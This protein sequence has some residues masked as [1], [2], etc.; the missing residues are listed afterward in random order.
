M[1]KAL[2]KIE[3]RE[4]ES[5]SSEEAKSYVEEDQGDLND[6]QKDMQ[7]ANTNLQWLSE[8][9]GKESLRLDE[10]VVQT[11][12]EIDILQDLLRQSLG[13]D[14]IILQRNIASFDKVFAAKYSLPL[15]KLISLFSAGQKISA[16]I[17][18]SSFTDSPSI[19]SF[20]LSKELTS[21]NLLKRILST[22]YLVDKYY[23]DDIFSL[24]QKYYVF[25]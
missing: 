23:S 13:A 10:K 19:S 25:N 9:L 14:L 18:P 4:K 12:E 24:L 2:E 21:K 7:I 1:P 20:H 6:L 15:H 3:E 22:I 16:T 11:N 5:S 17:S 8:K